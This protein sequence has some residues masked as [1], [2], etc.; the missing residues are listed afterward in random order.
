MLT[1]LAMFA[2]I[3]ILHVNYRRLNKQNLNN[4]ISVLFNHSEKMYF[5]CSDALQI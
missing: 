1:C 5:K 3:S 4:P 2:W